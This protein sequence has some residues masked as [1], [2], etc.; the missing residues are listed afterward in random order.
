ME[1]KHPQ[2]I[3][4]TL[5]TAWR[6]AASATRHHSLVE[7]YPLDRLYIEDL[8]RLR[9][10]FL[11][12]FKG[13][14]IRINDALIENPWM[15]EHFPEDSLSSME[16]SHPS[17]ALRFGLDGIRYRYELSGEESF[18]LKRHQLHDI[19]QTSIKKR[20]KKR[21]RNRRLIAFRVLLA[22]AVFMAMVL[23]WVAPTVIAGV[24]VA[25]L[26]CYF[27]HST[28]LLKLISTAIWGITIGMLTYHM[29]MLPGVYFLLVAGMMALAYL[30]HGFLYE[31]L[32]I[33]N[34]LP[35]DLPPA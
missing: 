23:A 22:E 3:E 18:N 12:N 17:M 25:C 26:A 21:D 35:T 4:T 33:E 8:Q 7:S 13:V 31:K 30:F 27:I 19:V 11:K 10:F 24:A 15:L 16:L 2:S 14:T 6:T 5:D 1:R 34:A 32:D 9:D 20:L 28:Q 29:P